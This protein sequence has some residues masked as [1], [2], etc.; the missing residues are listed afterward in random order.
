M[1]ASGDWVIFSTYDN[2]LYKKHTSD[3]D[4]T[5]VPSADGARAVSINQYGHFVYI[6]NDELYWNVGGTVHH[7]K[8][9]I[10]DACLTDTGKV[11]AL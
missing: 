4:F 2:K 1:D 8:S 7:V 9:N 11:F 3:A 5:H 6:V 10:K